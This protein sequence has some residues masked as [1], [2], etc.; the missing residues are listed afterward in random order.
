MQG[1]IIYVDYE[2]SSWRHMTYERSFRT[3]DLD[4]FKIGGANIEKYDTMEAYMIGKGGGS[5]FG[6]EWKPSKPEDERLIGKPGEIKVSYA[7]DGTKTETKIGEDGRAVAERHHT[8][9]PNAKYHTNPH[10][11]RIN[12]ETPRYGVPNFEKAHTNYWPDEYP[13][14]APEFKSYGGK[15]MHNSVEDYRFKTISEFKECIIRG[16]E[17]VFVWD[18]DEYGVCFVDSGYCIARTDGAL[19]K[20][21]STPDEVLEYEM[22]GD[23]LR[24][25]I[26]RV[27]VI[28]RTI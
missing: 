4:A 11:H 9:A 1:N 12:W 27:T 21:C 25:V 5:A 22:H 2:R 20:L 18:G 15:T 13:N 17:P 3:D 23:R 7:K 10:D 19:E 24:D 6:G 8:T 14:G 28:S 16:G 26:T